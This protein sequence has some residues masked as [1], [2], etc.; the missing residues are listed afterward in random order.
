LENLFNTLQKKFNED[1]K[2]FCA[3]QD[4]DDTC[5]YQTGLAAETL[6][7]LHSLLGNTKLQALVSIGKQ[8]APLI[9]SVND[10]ITLRSVATFARGINKLGT[11][12]PLEKVISA[13]DI[14]ALA[15][16]FISASS[17]PATS[18]TDIY[19]FIE[20]TT[21]VAGSSISSPIHVS[22]LTRDAEGA[23]FSLTAS[24]LFG[25]SVSDKDVKV[26]VN[27]IYK[28]SNPKDSLLLKA[29][30]FAKKDDTTF[31]W[32]ATK[33]K[34]FDSPGAFN[35][36]IE[37]GPSKHKVTRSYKS[38]ASNVAVEDLTIA[39]RGVPTQT[40]K[41]GSKFNP[42]K[43]TVEALS[44]LTI[45][46]KLTGDVTPHQVFTRFIG[47]NDQEA[48]YVAK[49]SGASSYRLD[50][51]LPKLGRA[52]NFVNGTYDVQIL[53]GDASFKEQ[54][55]WSA[56]SIE[57]KFTETLALNDEQQL[58]GLRKEITHIF[59]EPAKR[60]SQSI[61]T[62]FTG[63][64]GVPLFI[65]V[66]GL[67]TVGFNFR[68]FPSGIDAPLALVFIVLIGAMLYVLARFFIDV[69]V[70]PTMWQLSILA[71]FGVFIGSR[72]LT[73]VS[74]KRIQASN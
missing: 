17:K 44:R 2:A 5:V 71:I 19:D 66:V 45:S 7:I 59:P 39:G 63:L 22:Q 51:S 54:I 62:L 69:T 73:A 52:V 42:V 32:D 72:V 28:G 18:L 30:S 68:L 13:N 38:F 1:K 23:V 46:F 21:S 58:Y 49:S 14:D 16:Y 53:I 67:L 50:L 24:N 33:T 12:V 43:V 25:Q 70:F 6:S 57:L 64:V 74:N 47:D 20:G 4:S 15:Q 27:S 29:A 65:F 34:I 36:D 41:F 26:T 48:I 3:S 55:Q 8:I 10:K 9:Q 11:I 56:G 40:V 61:S 37:V 35:F 60:A 31:S